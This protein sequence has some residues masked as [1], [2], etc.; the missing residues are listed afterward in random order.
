MPKISELAGYSPLY[1]DDPDTINFVVNIED[2][3][4][5]NTY[6][7][8]FKDIVDSVCYHGLCSETVDSYL[9]TFMSGYTSN[10]I[11]NNISEGISTISEIS[12]VTKYGDNMLSTVS[13]DDLASQIGNSIASNF[14][15][16][17]GDYVT[18]LSTISSSEN[19]VIAYSDGYENG[20][21]V[22]DNFGETVFNALYYNTTPQID[23]STC[24]IAISDSVDHAPLGHITVGDLANYIRTML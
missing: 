21:R 1:Y 7:T 3:G 14:S 12:L 11:E 23:E 8:T 4:E 17:M 20:F 9:S 24:L 19:F 6:T 18:T 5:I 16:Y 2:S 15:N 13:G 22:L 10:Y